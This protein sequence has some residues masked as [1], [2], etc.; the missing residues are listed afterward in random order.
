MCAGLMSVA[1]CSARKEEPKAQVDRT[2]LAAFKPLPAVMEAAS[3]PL[4][5]EK[6]A[7][8]RMLYYETRLSK[9]KD[10]SCNSCHNLN[11]FGAD[12]GPVS[13]GF[14]GQK[15]NRNSPTVY[16]AAGHI[17]QFWDGRAPTVEEQA[18][19]PVLNP[20]EMAMAAEKE[21][22]ATLKGIPGYVS[23]FKRAFPE[24]K[25]PVTF[26]NMALAIGAF[27]RKL[28]T[29]ARWDKYL[30]GDDSALTETEKVGLVKFL[31]TGCQMCHSGAYMGGTMYQ[32]LGLAKPWPDTNDPGR[33]AVTK[34]E[35]DRMLFKVPSLRNIEKTGPYYH[36]GSVPTLQAAVDKMAEHQ[37]GKTLTAEDS[38]AI[39]VWLASLTGELPVEYIKAPVLP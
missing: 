10:V 6:V 8:G 31:D 27:E 36:D 4:T 20:V 29:P 39:T 24:D 33:F 16:N 21:V 2:R 30:N 25:D 13:E 35:H 7:L 22:V 37:L 26:D 9:G 38:K 28:V 12:T 34:A 14:G 17:A 3:N 32:K 1:G 15:G 23:A 11:T 5:E 19:G 18:K